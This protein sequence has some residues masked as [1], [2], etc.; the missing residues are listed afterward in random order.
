MEKLGKEAKDKITGFQGIITSKH[1]YL[2]G[3]SQYALTPKVD[4]DGKT[5]DTSY[6]DEG[7]LEIIGEGIIPQDVQSKDPGCDFREHP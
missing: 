7:R 5:Q 2:Y 1:I 6:F 3:C 4:K